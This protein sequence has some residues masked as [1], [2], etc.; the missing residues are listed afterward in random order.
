MCARVLCEKIKSV[1]DKNGI[2]TVN[3]IGVKGNRICETQA[4]RI[5]LGA[6]KERKGTIINLR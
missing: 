3:Q 5:E 1:R 2:T 6:V 4:R